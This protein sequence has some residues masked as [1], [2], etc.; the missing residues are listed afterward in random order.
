MERQSFPQELAE[1]GEA[2]S[3]HETD[4]SSNVLCFKVAFIWVGG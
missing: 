2:V 1:R 3:L 4:S